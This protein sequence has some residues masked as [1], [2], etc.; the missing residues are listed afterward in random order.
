MQGQKS[1]TTLRAAWE[2]EVRTH[3]KGALH[4]RFSDNHDEALEQRRITGGDLRASRAGTRSSWVAV[5]LS[6]RPFEGAVT[7][8]KSSGFVDVTPAAEPRP[9][10]PPSLALEGWGYRVL[11]RPRAS[12]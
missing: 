2:E 9:V 4:L 6:S 5:N 3:P 11:R 7:L 8:E 1:A 10:S 12:G